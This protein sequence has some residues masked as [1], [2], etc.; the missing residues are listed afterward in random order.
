MMN[1]IIIIGCCCLL[2][3]SACSQEIS[4]VDEGAINWKT[5]TNTYS[6][7][8]FL[9]MRIG[10]Y[11]KYDDGNYISI[12]DTLRIEGA[13]FYKF[14]SL[15]G[16]D[17]YGT[18]Y[19][20]LDEDNNLIERSPTN[21]DWVY[22]HAKFESEVGTKFYT[23]NDRT[24]NDYEVTLKSLFSDI[25]VF[26]FEMMYHPLLK[27]QKHIVSYKKGLGFTGNWKETKIDNIV[28]RYD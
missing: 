13:L 23:L 12:T 17:A 1:K 4:E 7:D 22:L 14:E 8:S 20:R 18:Q 27:G 2:L 28:Y 5:D 25:I 11:W 3:L 6:S 24:V 16:Y 15:T 9:P 10:N 21:P 26:E 19:Q